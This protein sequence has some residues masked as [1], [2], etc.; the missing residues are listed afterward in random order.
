MAIYSLALLRTLRVLCFVV[1]T[2]HMEALSAKLCSISSI[3]K[4]IKATFQ[5][6]SRTDFELANR[7]RS[8]LGG[9]YTHHWPKVSL[10]NEK[11]IEKQIT[12]MYGAI[13]KADLPE[14]EAEKLHA[15]LN[16]IEVKFDDI[17][18]AKDSFEEIDEDINRIKYLIEKSRKL[19]ADNSANRNNFL[20]KTATRRSLDKLD[21]HLFK[22]TFIHKL[23]RFFSATAPFLIPFSEVPATA[24]NALKTAEIGRIVGQY[25]S[26]AA[27]TFSDTTIN[28]LAIPRIPNEILLAGKNAIR[29]F[30]R[31]D[32]LKFTKRA[33]TIQTGVN[34]VVLTGLW[35]EYRRRREAEL[36]RLRLIHR[37]SPRI[38]NLLNHDVNYA[39]IKELYG[40]DNTITAKDSAT[41]REVDLEDL[42]TKVAKLN[43]SSRFF[44]YKLSGLVEN[45]TV[46]IRAKEAS[47]DDS[48]KNEVALKILEQQHVFE[49]VSNEFNKNYDQS[50]LD[51]LKPFAAKKESTS[52]PVVFKD[53][54]E[55]N[56]LIKFIHQL[57]RTVANEKIFSSRTAQLY[58]QNYLRK[59]YENSISEIIDDPLINMDTYVYHTQIEVYSEIVSSMVT[60][61]LEN[62]RIS[63]EDM[64]DI[65]DT[66]A[67][68]LGT[69]PELI[70]QQYRES[71]QTAEQETIENRVDQIMLD[72]TLEDH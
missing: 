59:K 66:F 56:P 60:E 44:N 58:I 71:Q 33:Q 27:T 67:E 68:T 34:T 35:L 41:L 50:Y 1:M 2:I 22:T 54:L 53:L 30:Q 39:D 31:K 55:E 47:I 14:E 51:N 32:P 72:K 21:K 63:P 69:T 42:K 16:E 48:L 70:E 29:W 49:L 43:P 40:T 17:K 45:N 61:E 8:Y 25:G 18:N 64:E 37:D 65:W 23:H 62:N 11:A 19:L 36:E 20:F 15:N 4:A 6:E 24:S 57:H 10:K 52:A 3:A 13:A 7:R 5:T 26:F 38:Q 12:A 9:I 28:P 46:F